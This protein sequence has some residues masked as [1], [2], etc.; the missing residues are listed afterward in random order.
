MAI[1][2]AY[3]L[4]QLGESVK[5]WV[6]S[7]VPHLERRKPTPWIEKLSG[8]R[9]I[10]DLGTLT[11][12]FMAAPN[13]AT[14]Q[15]SWGLFDQGNF[16]GHKFQYSEFLRTRNMLLGIITHLVSVLGGIAISLFPVRWLIQK[17][18]FKPGQGPGKEDVRRDYI[19]MRGIA[20]ADSPESSRAFAKLSWNGSM[21][22]LTGVFL[23]EAA[24]VILREK[25]AAHDLGGG[26]LTP[27]TLG[28]PF[29][30]RL[31]RAGL[32]LETKILDF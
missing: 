18:M 32:K 19:E 8:T 6:M 21:Y 31:Q 15:R 2:D 4:D 10:Q 17:F 3:T 28:H 27:A 22:H 12:S 5:P 13:I 29:I 16:Y 24:M 30:D 20:I 26:F 14:V 9:Y 23:A 1:F 11:N 25:T 7:P